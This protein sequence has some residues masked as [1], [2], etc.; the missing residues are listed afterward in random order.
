LKLDKLDENLSVLAAADLKYRTKDANNQTSELIG[1]AKAEQYFADNLFDL[2]ELGLDDMNVSH[3]GNGLEV[4]SRLEKLSL[5]NTLLSSLGDLE[6]LCMRIASLR[7]LDV[8]GNRFMRS[9]TASAALGL[10]TLVLNECVF[11]CK[12]DLNQLLSST[13]RLKFLSLN[14]AKLDWLHVTLPCSLEGLSIE[15][16]GLTSWQQVKHITEGLTQLRSLDMSDNFQI[17]NLFDPLL[18]PSSLESLSISHC[19]ITEWN[20]M[21]NISIRLPNL[22][23]LKLTGNN[24]YEVR[25]PHRQLIIALFPKLVLLNNATIS[26]IQRIESERYIASRLLKTGKDDWIRDALSEDRIMELINQYGQSTT[27]QD[28]MGETSSIGRRVK[29]TYSVSLKLPTGGTVPVK[30]PIHCQVS[31]LRTIVAKRT[32]WPFKLSEMNICFSPTITGE[33]RIVLQGSNEVD[34]IG[35]SDGYYMHVSLID[36]D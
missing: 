3:I 24:I 20:T 23:G 30:V 29:M 26:S 10:T 11:A 13:Q 34:D 14:R 6:E 12:S 16:V 2:S 4:F 15:S 25:G 33:D 31:H 22:I 18:L 8:S 1:Q 19:G 9:Y 5:R 28:G 27:E 35:I 36:S 32:S 17:F 7:E 21:K